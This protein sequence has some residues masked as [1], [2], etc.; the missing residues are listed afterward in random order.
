M[1]KFVV[2]SAFLMVLFSFVAS[3]NVVYNHYDTCN[4]GTGSSSWPT[5]QHCTSPGYGHDCCGWFQTW[6]VHDLTQVL[7]KDNV[8]SLTVQ[9]MP[10]ESSTCIAHGIVSV[11]ENI[12]GSWTFVGNTDDTTNQGWTYSTT[13][14]FSDIPIDF[15]Y[16]KVEASGCNN[17]WSSAGVM[18][19]EDQIPE[20]TTFGALLAVL[21]ATIAIV[22]VK[23]K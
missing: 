13:K 12:D 14:T 15:R 16:V 6:H 5:E 11:S 20:F 23:R 8:D 21:G 3:A 2:L 17:D 18:I 9:F 19:S 10:G 4:T 7:D 1:N 22:I